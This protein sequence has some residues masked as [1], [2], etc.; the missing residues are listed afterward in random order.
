MFWRWGKSADTVLV[1]VHVE[2]IEEVDAEAWGWATRWKWPAERMK[3]WARAGTRIR[4][5]TLGVP[6]EVEKK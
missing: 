4:D 2:V 5:Q 3:V 6:A 1:G